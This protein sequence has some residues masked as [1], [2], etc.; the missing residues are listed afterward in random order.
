M[1]TSLTVEEIQLALLTCDSFHPRRNIAVGNVSHGLL[2]YEAD[3]LVMSK[4][5][6]LT[7]IE[8]KRTWEDFRADFRKKHSHD[9]EII[10]GLYYCVPNELA[11]KVVDFLDEK[12]YGVSGVIGY[13]EEKQLHWY[14][15]EFGFL[16]SHSSGR[17]LFLEEQ[18]QLARLGAMRVWKE[19]SKKH[20]MNNPVK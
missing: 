9:D 7:E 5:G 8:I 14:R 20:N 2:S 6:Y 16:K 11:T 18:L 19:M 3:L 12:E 17:K 15:T 1:T 10:N 13:T 4:A